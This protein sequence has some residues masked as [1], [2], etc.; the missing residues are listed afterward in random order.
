MLGYGW[1]HPDRYEL[2]SLVPMIA[3]FA[4]AVDRL[5]GKEVRI[6]HPW[7]R[8]TGALFYG[9]WL[10]PLAAQVTFRL[11]HRREGTNGAVI[12]ALGV[13]LIASF[14][15]WG[16]HRITR[17]GIPLRG[18]L[19]RF[20]LAAALVLLVLGRDVKLYADWYGAR[21]HL[22]YD[23]SRD[24][25]RVLPDSAVVGGFWA[26]ALLATSHKRA[27]FMTDLWGPVNLSDPIGRFGLTHLVVTGDREYA[28]LDSVTNGRLSTAKVIRLYRIN[29]IVLLGVA[30]L[31]P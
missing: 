3:G 14:G 26:P 5:L 15:L 28:L 19:L 12:V 11:A 31:Q 4:F 8:L 24:L 6:G 29:N 23:C 27:L 25:D 30:E 18:R 17:G 10:W 9:L 16:L 20:G 21:T 22:M 1:Y 2:F 7:P 13:G